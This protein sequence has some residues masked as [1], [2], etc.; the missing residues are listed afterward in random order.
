[1]EVVGLD[2]AVVI[3][4]DGATTSGEEEEEE[5]RLAEESPRMEPRCR[6]SIRLRRSR[7]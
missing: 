4:T 7:G 3:G 5:E 6:R 2:P 1:M